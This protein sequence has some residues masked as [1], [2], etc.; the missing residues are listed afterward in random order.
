VAV[1]ELGEPAPVKMRELER[2]SGVGRETIRYYIGLGLLPEPS[3][4]KPNVADYTEEHV[5]RLATIRRLQAERYM[6]LSF[7]K[8]LLDRP[9]HGEVEGIPGFAGL[10]AARMGIAAHG[11]AL[12]LAEAAEAA[13][14]PVDELQTLIAEGVVFASP[15]AE[16]APAW[17]A[18]LDVAV[19]RAWGRVRAAGYAPETGFFAEDAEIYA[20]VLA[21]LAERE[22]DR[23]FTRV[24]GGRSIDDA[25]ALAQAGIELINELMTAMRTNYL[26]RR[27][28]ELGNGGAGGAV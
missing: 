5:S 20:Q 13:G 18:P 9:S 1:S 14:L 27:V 2:R 17:L 16:G 12:S 4:P 8:T 15:D 11:P 10:L 7:I 19:A 28:A 26:L 6:P 23:F 22:I 3:R 21:P 25:A 24:P